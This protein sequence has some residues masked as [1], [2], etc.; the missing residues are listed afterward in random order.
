MKGQAQLGLFESAE[1]NRPLRSREG[2][3]IV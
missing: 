3:E 1:E 2:I